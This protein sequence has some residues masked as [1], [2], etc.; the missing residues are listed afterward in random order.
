MSSQLAVAA[1]A[2]ER[3]N[4]SFFEAFGLTLNTRLYEPLA[5]TS[6]PEALAE[7]TGRWSWD[8]GD[9]FAIREIGDRLDN[10]HI[11]AVRK[12]SIGTQA[13]HNHIPVMVH[14]RWADPICVIDLNVVAG[15]PVGLIGSEVFLHDRRQDQRP[16]GARLWREKVK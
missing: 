4:T 6:M 16:I 3:Y 8:R 15:I 1:P 13:W 5:A 12:K 2:A 11:F 10:L 14:E 9:R 7:V